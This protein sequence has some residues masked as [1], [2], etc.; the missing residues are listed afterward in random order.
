MNNSYSRSAALSALLF[1]CGTAQ[2]VEYKLTTGFSTERSDNVGRASEESG[3]VQ[4]DWIHKPTLRGLLNHESNNVQI[5]ADYLVEH[6]IYTE[7]VFDDRTRWTGRADLRWD[8]V[9]ELLQFN[10]T[11]SRT[12]TTEDSLIQDIETNRQVTSVTSVGPKLFFQPRASDQLSLEYRYSDISQGQVN[13]G[14]T[15]DPNVPQINSDSDRQLM[16]V[17][18][19]LGLSENRSLTAEVSRDKVDFKQNAPELEIDTAS[20]LYSSKGDAL[21]LDARA[22][23]T[24]I[25]RTLGRDKVDGVIGRLN[26]LWRVSGSGEI[27]VQASRSIN[28]Q[29][30]DVLR[31]NAN[32]AQGAVFENT[33]VNEVFEEN[34]LRV[35]YTHRWGRNTATLGYNLQ[36]KDFDDSAFAPDQSRD[37]DESGFT[38]FY[39]RRLTPRFDVRFGASI[40]EREFDGRGVDEDYVTADFRLDWQAGRAL[41]LFAGANY[42]ERD[43]TGVSPLVD[44]LSFDEFVFLFGFS[45]D[46]VNRYQLPQQR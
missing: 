8:A 12:E 37:E 28:D 2:A 3:L 25:D 42:E 39:S 40:L 18:Y 1:A 19:R 16:A 22:G 11:N 44:Q 33:D 27:N 5:S 9:P 45:F 17:A 26:L 6:R 30:D 15:I 10:A 7:E 24:T 46:L 43:A 32:F 35:S 31:G 21:E 36:N 4:K 20:L 34:A 29:S 41:T 38:A 14:A 13:T 23:Y